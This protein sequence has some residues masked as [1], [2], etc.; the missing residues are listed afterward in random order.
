MKR[1]KQEKVTVLVDWRYGYRVEYLYNFVH[2][3]SKIISKQRVT[4]LV[5]GVKIIKQK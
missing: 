4:A 1:W 5:E 3:Q 2:L